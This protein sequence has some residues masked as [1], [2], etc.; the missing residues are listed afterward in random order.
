[1]RRDVPESR[2]LYYLKYLYKQRTTASGKTKGNP[3]ITKNLQPTTSK[4]A[5]IGRDTAVSPLF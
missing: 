3:K 4:V 5:G 1:M 2:L